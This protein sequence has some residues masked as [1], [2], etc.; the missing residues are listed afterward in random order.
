MQ[1]SALPLGRCPRPLPTCPRPLLQHALASA[2]LDHLITACLAMP[3]RRD[4]LIVILPIPLPQFARA[5]RSQASKFLAKHPRPGPD[6]A[7]TTR[8]SR[9]ITGLPVP[10][11]PAVTSTAGRRGPAFVSAFLGAEKT[12]PSRASSLVSAGTSHKTCRLSGGG[13]GEGGRGPPL[14][15]RP[16]RVAS[17]SLL[18]KAHTPRRPILRACAPANRGRPWRARCARCLGR[19][20]PATS[21]V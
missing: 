18:A 14:Q 15:L 21:G 12:M 16:G 6:S 10:M 17:S 3:P 1:C 9:D 11:A 5:Y 8:L 7:S 4:A 20:C 13:H 2:A 19:I